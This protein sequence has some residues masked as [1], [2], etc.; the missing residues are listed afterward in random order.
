L[1]FWS[2]LVGSDQRLMKKIDQDTVHAL[3]L[4]APGKLRTDETTAGGLV[5]SGQ[6]FA[7]FNVDERS[8]IWARMKGYDGLIPSLHTF[9]EDFKYLESCVHCLRR[10]LSWSHRSVKESM[11]AMFDPDSASGENHPEAGMCIIQTSESTFRLLHATEAECLEAG[12]QQL[13]LYA[14]R[15]YPLMPPDPKNTDDLMA[16]PTRASPDPRV[17]YDMAHLAHRLG[18]RSP[19]IDGLLNSSPDHQIARSALL[20]A[21]KPGQYRYDDQQFDVMV[22]RIVNCFTE[23]VPDQPGPSRDL[24]ADRTIKLRARSGV[25]QT[26]THVQ[27]APFLFLDRLHADVD[28]ANTITSFFVRRCVYFAF[29]GNSSK[30]EPSA[31]TEN[32]EGV[33][34]MMESPLFVD[35][36]GSLNESAQHMDTSGRA[37]LLDRGNSPTRQLIFS[38]MDSSET[39]PEPMDLDQISP[40]GGDHATP[41]Q[42]HNKSVPGTVLS[43]YSPRAD[44]AL[45]DTKSE[46]TQISLGPVS[47]EWSQDEIATAE[48]LDPDTASV[49]ENAGHTPINPISQRRSSSETVNL[50]RRKPSPLSEELEAFLDGL[51]RAQSEQEELEERMES[52][53]LT[54]ELNLL[55]HKQTEPGDLIVP[56][57]THNFSLPTSGNRLA[58]AIHRDTEHITAQNV[59]PKGQASTQKLIEIK[60]WSLERGQWNQSDC[61]LVDRTDP[62]PVER[63]ARKYSCKCYA[64]YDVDLHSLRPGHCYRA[65]TADGSNAIFLISAHE[66]NQLAA[67]GRFGKERQLVSMASRAVAGAVTR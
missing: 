34:E 56:D 40:S 37:S 42:S 38:E 24:L 30:V 48:E 41:R 59:D 58:E 31:T 5:L 10:L 44:P 14:M 66:E 49:F 51:R 61:L 53:R 36:H 20:Q 15:H 55:H 32:E 45:E 57:D 6:V 23:A 28:V 4:L 19:E 47:L 21:R 35:N 64:L 52:D 26:R 43:R 13:W 18:F 63:I 9:F 27:D 33:E 54:E 29:L 17:I 62:T 3:Q 2:S 16:K 60:F 67:D 8:A 1:D 12:Y 46:C 65:A 39:A 25:P 11:S 50:V 7:E 22:R